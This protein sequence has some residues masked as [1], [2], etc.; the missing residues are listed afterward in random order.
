MIVDLLDVRV[1]L[2]DG[3][4]QRDRCALCDISDVGLLASNGFFSHDIA[5]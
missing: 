4:G 1:H 3:L 5:P 2:N